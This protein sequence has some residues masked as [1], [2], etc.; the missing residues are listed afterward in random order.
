MT[1]VFRYVQKKPS[2]ST[3]FVGHILGKFHSPFHGQ[4]SLSNSFGHT[5]YGGTVDLVNS[6][7]ETVAFI[8]KEI[9]GLVNCHICIY[10]YTYTYDLHMLTVF[11]EN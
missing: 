1:S 6:P 3:A 9:E 10:I 4:L 11:S 5:G 8:L 2:L 7:E